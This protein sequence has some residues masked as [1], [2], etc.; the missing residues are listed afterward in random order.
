MTEALRVP[1][2]AGGLRFVR[3]SR[4]GA[5]LQDPFLTPD[6]EAAFYDRYPNLAYDAAPWELAFL[7]ER[8]R[9]LE[10]WAPRG[11]LLD[12]GCGRGY[13]VRAAC[14]RGWEAYGVEVSRH[15]EAAA[16]PDVAARI[17]VGELDGGAWPGGA[18]DVVT[19][20]HVIEHLRD[21]RRALDRIRRL[22][23]PGG[24]LVVATPDAGSLVARVLRDRWAA[25]RMPDHCVVYSRRS[26]WRLLESS[27]FAI[28]HAGSA[29][30]PAAV[31]ASAGSW[32]E[33]VRRLRRRAF[34]FLGMWRGFRR[35]V[36]GG[37]VALGLGDALEV[38]C[39][40]GRS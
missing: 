36:R 9:R 38:V 34:E 1:G 27:G 26:L 18:F 8:L 31:A 37:V 15:V 40:S 19:L 20:Y 22:L 29:G 14:R 13:F 33:P 5:F 6:Q 11:R 35:A 12:V 25:L 4:C 10:R 23:K 2:A 7:E 16:V 21:P 28:L 39:R 32:A 3:C 30:Q 24:I 17:R